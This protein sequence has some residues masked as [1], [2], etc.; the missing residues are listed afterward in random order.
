MEPL[1][2]SGTTNLLKP[3]VNFIRDNVKILMGPPVS[4]PR[5]KA[6]ITIAKKENISRP[7]AQFRQARHIAEYYARK[8]ALKQ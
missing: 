4:R 3:G 7:D 6:I 1:M 2:Q 5:K 8:E